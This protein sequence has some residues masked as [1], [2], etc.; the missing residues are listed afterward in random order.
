[1]EFIPMTRGGRKLL[2]DGYAYI[3]DK[4]KGNVTYWRCERKGSCGGRLKTEDE[5]IQGEAS[6]H[7]HPP[8]AGRNLSLKTIQKIKERAKQ[9]EEVTSTIIQNCTSEYPLDA[10]G[11]LPKKRNSGKIGG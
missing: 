3:V 1:M 4:Q 2:L 9:L 7:S 8:D 10:A 5:V 11:A 6:N